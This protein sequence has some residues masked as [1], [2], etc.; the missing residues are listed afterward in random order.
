MLAEVAE[1]IAAVLAHPAEKLLSISFAM[2]GEVLGRSRNFAA[3]LGLSPGFDATPAAVPAS[4]AATTA[5]AATITA[6][7]LLLLAPLVLE[8]AVRIRNGCP[9]RARAQRAR[10]PGATSFAPARS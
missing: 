10:P 7:A 2:L 9:L 4:A 3:T 6:A 8:I 5:A 1:V